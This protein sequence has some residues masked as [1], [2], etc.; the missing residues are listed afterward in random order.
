MIGATMPV[1]LKDDK[2]L[3]DLVEKAKQHKISA[4][5][6]R[7]QRASYVYGNMPKDAEATRQ[8]VEDL[9]AKQDRRD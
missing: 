2:D 1:D 8:R 7:N 9:L 5:E 4:E 3:L 6:A